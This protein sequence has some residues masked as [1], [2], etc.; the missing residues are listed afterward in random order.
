[1][2]NEDILRYINYTNIEQSDKEFLRNDIWHFEFVTSPLAVY[3]PGNDLLQARLKTFSYT[4]DES[5]STPETTIRQ[6]KVRQTMH[7]G[8]TSGTITLDFTDRE[9]QAISLFKEDWCQKISS[10]S[11]RFAYRKVDTICDCKAIWFN[12]TRTPIRTLYFYSC[13]ITSQPEPWTTT[14]DDPDTS[15]GDISIEMAFEH[16]EQQIHL[17]D[18]TLNI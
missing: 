15:I 16:Y 7:G 5:L 4:T 18:A 8:T 11:T 6:F 3:F 10:R 14:S 12:T 2:V 17:S 13:Q 9:D 1:M